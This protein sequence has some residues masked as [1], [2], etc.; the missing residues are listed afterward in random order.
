VCAPGTVGTMEPMDQPDQ[1]TGFI[2]AQESY[3]QV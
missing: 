1:L 2:N 3:V